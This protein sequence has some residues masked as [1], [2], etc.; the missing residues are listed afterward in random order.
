MT[1]DFSTQYPFPASNYLLTIDPK[2]PKYQAAAFQRL[3]AKTLVPLQMGA[4]Q[5]C[6]PLYPGIQ[7]RFRRR[8]RNISKKAPVK[9]TYRRKFTRVTSIV[10]W[11]PS[12]S[13]SLELFLII[14]WMTIILPTITDDSMNRNTGWESFR[15]HSSKLIHIIIPD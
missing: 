8:V 12:F 11:S 7:T 1:I 9:R 14:F 2:N 10:P 13:Q 4:S 15:F 5:H 6:I 3:T